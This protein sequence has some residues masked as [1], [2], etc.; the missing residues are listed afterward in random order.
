M[1]LTVILSVI[2]IVIVIGLTMWITK[3][4]YSRKWD[5]EDTD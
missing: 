5:E 4:A 1:V 3:K 2:T